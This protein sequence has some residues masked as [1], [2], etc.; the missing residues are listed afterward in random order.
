MEQPSNSTTGEVSHEVQQSNPLENLTPKQFELGV[1]LYEADHVLTKDDRKVMAEDLKG[2]VLR[3]HFWALVN[4]ITFGYIPTFYRNVSEMR[5]PKIKKSRY[6]RPTIN[7][8]WLSVG[9]ALAALGISYPTE[10]TGLWNDKIKT[11]SKEPTA[12]ET[13]EEVAQ[14]ARLVNVWRAMPW[15]Q[16]TLFYVYYSKTIDDSTFILKDP[17]H[18]TNDDLHQVHYQPPRGPLAAVQESTGAHWDK[19]RAA[20]GFQVASSEPADSGQF[21]SETDPAEFG[22]PDAKIELKETEEHRA[23]PKSAWEAIRRGNK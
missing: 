13:P 3:A 18:F 6:T 16:A 5:N 7:R 22:L 19:I 8:P 20:N 9:I 14:R 1:K 21:I 15:Q 4:T 23:S 17:R 10:Y 11:L 12:D 2:V